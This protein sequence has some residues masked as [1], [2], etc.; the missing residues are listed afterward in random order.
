MMMRKMWKR[1]R[2][3][4]TG[5]ILTLND[6]GDD[7]DNDD[8]DDGDDDAYH[9]DKIMIFFPAPAPFGTRERSSLITSEN[10]TSRAGEV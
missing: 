5:D 2:V 1:H 4:V 6:D 8:D 10:K 3:I 7:D 9:D